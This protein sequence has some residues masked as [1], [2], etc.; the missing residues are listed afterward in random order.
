MRNKIWVWGLRKENWPLCS[1]LS[2]ILICIPSLDEFFFLFTLVW[3]DV[4]LS[5]RCTYEFYIKI[6]MTSSQ[7]SP[8]FYFFFKSEENRLVDDIFI[9]L[10]LLDSIWFPLTSHNN[11]NH[12]GYHWDNFVD[13]LHQLMKRKQCFH[14][15]GPILFVSQLKRGKRKSNVSTLERLPWIPLATTL[16]LGGTGRSYKGSCYSYKL[17]FLCSLNWLRGNKV[18]HH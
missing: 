1:G 17:I 10:L 14:T 2:A 3:S 5:A 4:S 13:S 15:E 12:Y 8:C 6:C 16:L 18:R 9:E 7:S 11:N